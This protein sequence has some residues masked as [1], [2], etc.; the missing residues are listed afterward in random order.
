MSISNLVVGKANNREHD[1]L[2]PLDQYS[3]VARQTPSSN[4]GPVKPR[5]HVGPKHPA[6]V[7]AVA[8]TRDQP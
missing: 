1:K 8:P 7:D 3:S 5:K 4:L 2:P 6:S